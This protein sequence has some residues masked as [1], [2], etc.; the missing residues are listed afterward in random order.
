MTKH[1]ILFSLVLSCTFILAACDSS[2]SGTYTSRGALISQSM[3]FKPGGK[4]EVTAMG[5]TQE[6]NYEVE[7]KKVKIS[8]A[9]STTILTIDEK[10]C[11]DAGGMAGTFCKD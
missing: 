7:G 11:L 4:V 3:M 8:I 10:G 2:L 9:G 6:G 1:P 5:M